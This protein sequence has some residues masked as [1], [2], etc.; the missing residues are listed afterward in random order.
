MNVALRRLALIVC[1]INT[2]IFAQQPQPDDFVE[3][4]ARYDA[5]IRT[6]DHPKKT[7]EQVPTAIGKVFG[8]TLWAYGVYKGLRA[9]DMGKIAMATLSGF[10][11]GVSVA[12]V[13]KMVAEGTHYFKWLYKLYMQEQSIRTLAQLLNLHAQDLAKIDTSSYD[14]QTRQM[15]VELQLE[16]PTGQAE[17]IA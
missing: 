6:I 3:A 7:Y 8:I 14:E 16:L 5:I 4:V 11:F 9:G 12:A 17:K 13:S 10:T 1:I 2:T 15:L